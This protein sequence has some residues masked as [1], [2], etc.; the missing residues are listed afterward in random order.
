MTTKGQEHGLRGSVRNKNQIRCY[1]KTHFSHSENIYLWHLEYFSFKRFYEKSLPRI[2]MRILICVRLHFK[3]NEIDETELCIVKKIRNKTDYLRLIEEVGRK[4]R[5]MKENETKVRNHWEVPLLIFPIMW[6]W[7]F[8]YW[9]NV[10]FRFLISMVAFYLGQQLEL[11]NFARNHSF[12]ILYSY[13]YYHE[14]EP[15]GRRGPV[16]LL[17]NQPPLF[18]ISSHRPVCA[19]LISWTPISMDTTLSSTATDSPLAKGA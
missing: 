3:H 6:Q 13:S 15:Q 16:R 12:T 1:S 17:F 11:K 10:R 14:P 2:F 4:D 8:S 7:I 18:T 9:L 19:S 5:K